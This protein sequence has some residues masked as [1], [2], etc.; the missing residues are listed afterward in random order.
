[1]LRGLLAQQALTRL[2]LVPRVPLEQR[3]RLEQRALKDPL[4]IRGLKVQPVLREQPDHKDPQVLLERQVLLDLLALRE[5]RVR[6]VIL[7]QPV[8]RQLLR[9]EPQ[10]LL[11]PRVHRVSLI[12]EHRRLP[13]LILFYNKELLAQRGPLDPLVARLRFQQQHRKLLVRVRLV[14]ARML[15]KTI[16]FTRLRVWV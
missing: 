4:V 10:Q 7:V 6:Q 2:C 3:E 9:W 13:H 1:M 12:V 14:R 15:P 11:A 5:Q 8:L 16:T